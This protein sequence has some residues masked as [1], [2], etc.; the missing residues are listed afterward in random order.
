MCLILD[1][2]FFYFFILKISCL[3]NNDFLFFHILFVKKKT[4]TYLLIWLLKEYAKSMKLCRL[5]KDWEL[6]V[7]CLCFSEKKMK[8]E[9]MTEL[10]QIYLLVWNFFKMFFL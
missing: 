2:E 3:K 8:F 5:Q 6:M 4:R 9:H 1:N 7:V 10:L